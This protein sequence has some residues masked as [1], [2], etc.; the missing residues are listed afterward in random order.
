MYRNSP[1][2]RAKFKE[3]GLEP[4]ISMWIHRKAALY[5]EG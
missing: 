1:F 3:I 5:I 2:Y 4:E